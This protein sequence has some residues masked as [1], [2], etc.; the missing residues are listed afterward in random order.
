MRLLL[1]IMIILGTLESLPAHANDAVVLEAVYTERPSSKAEPDTLVRRI[2]ALGPNGSTQTLLPQSFSGFSLTAL[3]LS[4]GKD[5]ASRTTLAAF[6]NVVVKAT[7]DSGKCAG[8]TRDG[9]NIQINSKTPGSRV[10]ILSVAQILGTSRAPKIQIDLQWKYSADFLCALEQKARLDKAPRSSSAKEPLASGED[11]AAKALRALWTANFTAANGAPIWFSFC[12]KL[13]AGVDWDAV[14][15]HATKDPALVPDRGATRRSRKE[16]EAMTTQQLRE[17]H[18]GAL[19]RALEA[20]WEVMPLASRAEQLPTGY[21]G[22]NVAVEARYGVQLI[23]APTS[24]FQFLEQSNSE[25]ARVQRVADAD[26]DLLV[27][28]VDASLAT[29]LGTCEGLFSETFKVRVLRDDD[30]GNHVRDDVD[31][32]FVDSCT[33][34]LALSLADKIDETLELLLVHALDGKEYTVA[35]SG[36][37]QVKNL[38][39]VTSF[40]IVS[41][42]MSFAEYV[43]ANDPAA[44][45]SIP[46]SWA[47]PL[48][49]DDFG[50]VA[51]TLPWKL[52]FNPRA[53]PDLARYLFAFPHVSAILRTQ[54]STDDDGDPVRV[55]FGLGVGVAEAFTFSWAVDLQGDH[56]VLVGLSIPELASLGPR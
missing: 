26:A 3:R 36:R 8:M 6:R 38:G 37:F 40:P 27:T 9:S 12:G 55:A 11:A 52:A 54:Q 35:T 46:V 2:P 7:C 18:K 21:G 10:P 50:N 1:V 16:V 13:A 17:A 14:H 30:D 42:I 43:D 25:R 20:S 28:V 5:E 47:I 39:L 34:R 19:V 15:K 56:F 4:F 51:I 49:D 31:L 24:A 48:S 41:E 45:S 32:E 22:T 33:R 29:S 44:K 53:A 23:P